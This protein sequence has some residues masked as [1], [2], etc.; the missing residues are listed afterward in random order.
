M[1]LFII[2][3]W[4]PSH[5]YPLAGVF[6]QEQAEAIAELARD[7]RVLVSTW[8]HD[9]SELNLRKPGQILKGWSWYWRNRKKSEV[10]CKN[11][12]HEIFSATLVWPERLPLGRMQRLIAVNRKNLQRAV[13]Q[14]G[15][16]QVIHAHVSFPGGYIANVLSREFGIPYVLT[17]HMSPF[18]FPALLQQGQPRPEILEAFRGASASIAVSPTLADRIA[19][20][21]IERPLVVPN[22]V[23]ER[24]FQTGRPIS[25]KIIFFTLG[26]LTAQKGIDHLLQSIAHW[27]PPAE[28]FEFRIGGDGPQRAEYVDLAEKLQIS[29]RIRWLG[30]VSRAEAP[31]QFQEC[32]IYVMPS[33]HETFG[34]VYAE[35]MACGKPVIATRCGGPESIVNEI[36]GKLVEIGDV[37]GLAQTM[38][39]MAHQLDRYDSD[40]IRADF[41]ARFSRQ[42]VVPQLL[43]IYRRLLENHASPT[44]VRAEHAQESGWGSTAAGI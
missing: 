19:S 16:I 33:R 44:R 30:S 11:R 6:T 20:F 29:D 3:S 9:T 5:D 12:V 37:A 23:D 1:N 32:H 41:V 13:K 18:P 42:A 36:N 43:A 4:Y 39:T 22:I 15:D 24:R 38:R 17:E 26:G 10:T 35:A 40:K 21:G 2:P 34:V 8:G 28:Q 7:V 27:N 14:F 31:R 25:N